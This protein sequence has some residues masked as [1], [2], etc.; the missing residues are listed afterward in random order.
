MI[1]FFCPRAAS[2]FLKANQLDCRRWMG[3]MPDKRLTAFG[4]VKASRSG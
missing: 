4:R 1:A 2:R 3:F